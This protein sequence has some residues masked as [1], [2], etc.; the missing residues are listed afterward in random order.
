MPSG[1]LR[2]PLLLRLFRGSACANLDGGN[3]ARDLM[4]LIP[5]E[6][7][8]GDEAVA[9]ARRTHPRPDNR[10][11]LNA[12]KGIKGTSGKGKKERG[13]FRFVSDAIFSTAYPKIHFVDVSSCASQSLPNGMKTNEKFIDD[14][15]RGEWNPARN[16]IADRKKIIFL[17]LL[18]AARKEEISLHVSH[19]IRGKREENRKRLSIYRNIR[20]LGTQRGDRNVFI[21]IISFS[22]GLIV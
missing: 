6:Q 7:C 13:R 18:S 3:F 2:L 14:V 19:G 9:R 22:N 12:A 16:G 10:S 4:Q 11:Q 20:S 17:L 15:D 8:D 5:L 1:F 21:F